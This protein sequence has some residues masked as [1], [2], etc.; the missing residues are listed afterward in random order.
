MPASETAAF[1]GE[2][3]GADSVLLLVGSPVSLEEEAVSDED[4][5]DFDDV[6]D[7]VGLLR[8][9]LRLV[10]TPWLALAPLPPVP[11]TGADD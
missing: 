6:F 4:E 1:V 10:L 3:L 7:R 11:T 2:E 8:V 5:D 9:A